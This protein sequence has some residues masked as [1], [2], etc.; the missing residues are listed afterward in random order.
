MSMLFRLG[1]APSHSD[2]SRK[3]PAIEAMLDE[4]RHKLSGLVTDDSRLFMIWECNNFHGEDA[5]CV[6][7][8]EDCTSVCVKIVFNRKERQNGPANERGSGSW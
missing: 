7:K 2:E 6:P 5:I 8:E 3:K 4:I 1:P